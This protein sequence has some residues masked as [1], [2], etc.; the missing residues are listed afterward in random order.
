MHRI[1]LR[2]S[3]VIVE[4][5]VFFLC[6]ILKKTLQYLNLIPFF[7]FTL[8][9]LD[10]PLNKWGKTALMVC[11]TCIMKLIGLSKLVDLHSGLHMFVTFKTRSHQENFRF[12]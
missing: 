1:C 8:N 4:F 7:F 10:N 6:H 2:L 3:F 5:C 9:G 11:C 12:L